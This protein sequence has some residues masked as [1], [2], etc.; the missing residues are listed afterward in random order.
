MRPDHD[1]VPGESELA[2]VGKAGGQRPVM[3]RHDP[4]PGGGIEG[5]PEVLAHV[6]EDQGR[7][8][9]G[10]VSETGPVDSRP[11]GDEPG[12]IEGQLRDLARAPA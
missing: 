11:E 12:Q 9:A 7:L 6:F 2:Q 5:F 4:Q 3:V 10:G 1:L 8:A